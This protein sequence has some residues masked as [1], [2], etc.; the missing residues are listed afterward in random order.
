MPATT[1]RVCRENALPRLAWLCEA[2]DGNYAFTIGPGVDSGG[3]FVVE[4]VWHGPFAVEAV[5]ERYR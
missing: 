5:M 1:F 2:Q 4:G 3:D